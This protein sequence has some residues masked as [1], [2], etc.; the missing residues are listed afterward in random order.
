MGCLFQ[1][2]LMS[3][4]GAYGDQVMKNAKKMLKAKLFDLAG[5]DIHNIHHIQQLKLGLEKGVFHDLNDYDFKNKQL[6]LEVR[7]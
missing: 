2:N 7:V 4:S 6:F 5:T 1:I 3:L